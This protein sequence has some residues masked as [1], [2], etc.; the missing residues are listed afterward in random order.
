MG[1]IKNE[2]HF[3]N[4]IKSLLKQYAGDD[5]NLL[6]ANEYIKTIYN[7]GLADAFMWD[8]RDNIKLLDRDCLSDWVISK[9]T[10]VI[11]WPKE[12]EVHPVW[13]QQIKF[14]DDF[15]ALCSGLAGI[16]GVYLFWVDEISSPLYVGKSNNLGQRMISSYIEKYKEFSAHQTKVS[17]IQAGYSDAGIYELYFIS[18]MKPPLNKKDKN[19]DTLTISINPMVSFSDGILVRK[20]DNHG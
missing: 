16:P 12:S 2:A 8:L 7:H 5:L 3:I 14:T 13:M 20:G 18:K 11:Q 19:D 4:Y 6:S 1:Y 9:K 17:F 10:K 15:M